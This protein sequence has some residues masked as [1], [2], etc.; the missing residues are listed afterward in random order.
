VEAK[1]LIMSINKYQTADEYSIYLPEKVSKRK[2]VRWLLNRLMFKYR[3]KKLIKWAD[4]LHYTWDCAI[5]DGTDLIWARRYG[6]PI[7]IEWLGSDIRVPEKLCTINP[8]YQRIVEDNHEYVN[9]ETVERSN[10]NQSK[11]SRVNAQALVCPEM[12]FF[13]NTEIIKHY[14]IVFQR[15]DCFCF[16]PSY[17]DVTNKIPLIVHSPTAT[18]IKGTEIILRAVEELRNECDFD[19]RLIQNV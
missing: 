17:P 5:E 4:V 13:L 7:F 14:H 9:L 10:A 2:P 19:F 15:I 18:V 12:S 1:C 3:L 11:F 8:Y 16:L 6:K